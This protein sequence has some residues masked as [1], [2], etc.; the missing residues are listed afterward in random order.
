[1]AVQTYLTTQQA[2]HQ[3]N[4][5][6]R[7]IGNIKGRLSPLVS[8]F[9][10]AVRQWDRSIQAFNVWN[11][12]EDLQEQIS[13]LKPQL[14]QL[15]EIEIARSKY[16][17]EQLACI[18]PTEENQ[19]QINAL[20]EQ[21]TACADQA[22]QLASLSDTLSSRIKTTCD[23]A[24][25][26]FQRFALYAYQHPEKHLSIT[27]HPMP[28]P[29]RIKDPL[30]VRM[31]GFIGDTT[32]SAAKSMTRFFCRHPFISIGATAF[33]IGAVYTYKEELTEKL[34]EVVQ[35]EL[36]TEFVSDI[37]AEMKGKSQVMKEKSQQIAKSLIE[38]PPYAVGYVLANTKL[39]GWGGLKKL[40]SSIRQE[41]IEAAIAD[42]PGKSGLILAP[43]GY[44]TGSLIGIGAAA[45]MAA[46][47]VFLGLEAHKFCMRFK[48][49]QSS[50]SARMPSA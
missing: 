40:Y 17:L 36:V 38:H 13:E 49:Y 35:T 22:K 4:E 50:L 33:G 3:A 8:N 20:R 32:T 23:S 9:E 11:I 18:H 46:G 21:N 37:V 16:A 2:I 39:I 48:W 26:T 44:A 5:L 14:T 25:K 27:F 12:L 43:L 10:Q 24:E 15:H 19:D 31:V 30:L 47:G 45:G 1:M 29:K 42:H 6:M 7:D 34:K 28:K 41:G